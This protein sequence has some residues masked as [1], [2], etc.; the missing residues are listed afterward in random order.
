MITAIDTNILLDIF[1]PNERFAAESAKLLKL[2]YNKGAL[3]ICDIVYAELVPQFQD[4]QRLDNTLATINVS[5]SSTNADIAFLAGEK[6]RLYRKWA[7]R[8]N[9][10]SPISLSALML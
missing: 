9:E 2:A 1:L 7:E 8:E 10:S 4:R 6:W 5:L 3:I